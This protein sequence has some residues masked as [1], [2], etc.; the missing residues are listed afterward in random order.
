MKGTILDNPTCSVKE[1]LEHTDAKRYFRVEI[2]PNP[3]GGVNTYT[4]SEECNSPQQ[5]ASYPVKFSDPS[6][7]AFGRH[8]E[9]ATLLRQ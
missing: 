3:N 9:A 8:A 2:L 1:V 5:A 7:K 6:A 4:L